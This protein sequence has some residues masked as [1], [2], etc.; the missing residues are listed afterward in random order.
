MRVWLAHELALRGERRTT[1]ARRIATCA[2]L[3]L[4]LRH[5]WMR[6]EDSEPE[7]AL[8]Y[9]HD[10]RSQTLALVK[11]ESDA[12]VIASLEYHLRA[13]EDQVAARGRA[14]QELSQRQLDLAASLERQWEGAATHARVRSELQRLNAELSGVEST[15]ILDGEADAVTETEA[16]L[17]AARAL[18]SETLAAGEPIAATLPLAAPPAL[19]LAPLPDTAILDEHCTVAADAPDAQPLERDAAEAP[20]PPPAATFAELAWMV[21]RSARRKPSLTRVPTGQLRLFD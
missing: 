3:D 6:G 21:K 5:F 7:L 10:G 15:P 8:V 9:H 13:L 14:R 19:A 18:T 12:G 11:T 2:G 16:L 20:S 17:A 4:E 1:L